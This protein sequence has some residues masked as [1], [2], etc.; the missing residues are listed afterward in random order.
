LHTKSTLTA[1]APVLGAVLIAACGGTSKSG[2]SSAA[3][4]AA[5]Q[6]RSSAQPSSSTHPAPVAL[7]TTKHAK[8]GTVLAVGPKRLTVYLFEADKGGKSTCMGACAKVWP[9]VL[10]KPKAGRGASS[11]NLGTIKRPDGATQVTYRGH[12]LYRF[13]KD[14][15]DGDAYG[16]GIKSFGAEWYALEP[17]GAKL[18][19]S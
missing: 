8:L 17:S 5:S 13:V 4:P 6:S 16:Q 10:G 15:D 11:R 14:E 1:I 9:P 7:I 18:D 2:T 3:S 19:D 12:P